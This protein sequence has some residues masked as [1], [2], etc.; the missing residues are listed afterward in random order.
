M[1]G[2]QG[3]RGSAIAGRACCS[4]C[5]VL[6]AKQAGSTCRRGCSSPHALPRS[7]PRSAPPACSQGH[8]LSYAG[9][10]ALIYTLSAVLGYRSHPTVPPE[11]EL[12]L[13]AR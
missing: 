12:L 5:A 1:G 2:G 3:R 9:V 13:G 8:K 11:Q 7:A 10:S 4:G 6:V